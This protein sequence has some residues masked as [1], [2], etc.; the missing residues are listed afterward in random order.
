[1]QK[2]AIPGGFSILFWVDTCN[3]K[4][5]PKKITPLLGV[6]QLSDTSSGTLF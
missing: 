2:M 3:I 1:M 6:Q 4:T 5:N